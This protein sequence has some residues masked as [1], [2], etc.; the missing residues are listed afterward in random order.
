MDENNSNE[1]DEDDNDIDIE[2]VDSSRGKLHSDLKWYN[3]PALPRMEQSAF[4]RCT[5]DIHQAVYARMWPVVC[6]LDVSSFFCCLS[7]L[8]FPLFLF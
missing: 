7:W 5:E 2:M 6:Y 1:G 8:S 3:R 4:E